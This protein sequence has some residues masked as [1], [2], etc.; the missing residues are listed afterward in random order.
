[1]YQYLYNP[2]KSD[3]KRKMPFAEEPA[4][5]LYTTPYPNKGL[6]FTNQPELIEYK[7]KPPVEQVQKRMRTPYGGTK[8]KKKLKI[9]KPKK[10]KKNQ[11]K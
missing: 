3:N 4:N 11:K 8:D 2:K 5:E 7:D 9:K 1:M 6:V 10:T